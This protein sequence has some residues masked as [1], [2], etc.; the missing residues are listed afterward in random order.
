M[1]AIIAGFKEALWFERKKTIVIDSWTFQ[2]FNK[3]TAGLLVMGS[4]MVVARQFF[5]EPIR[6]DA[7]T[8]R[9]TRTL[10]TFASWTVESEAGV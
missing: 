1:A 8:V 9:T 6:C 3:V 2:A 7:G 10:R 4:V 5:G